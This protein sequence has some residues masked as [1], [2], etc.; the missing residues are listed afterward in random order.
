MSNLSIA[1][2]LFGKDFIGAQELSGISSRLFGEWIQ[3]F[4][5]PEVPEVFLERA[6]RSAGAY[7]LILGP[8]PRVGGLCLLDLRTR[9]GLDPAVSAPCFYNQDWYLHESFAR[10][11]TLKYEWN[12]IAKAI[13]LDSRGEDPIAWVAQKSEGLALPSALLCAYAFFANFLHSGGG[14]LWK[15]E[16]VWCSDVDH[17]GDQIYVG[18]YTDPAGVNKD[19]FSIH[20]HLRIRDYYGVAGIARP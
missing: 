13:A 8:P 10:V 11:T 3:P 1:R 19:G 2:S 12:M 17:Q 9:F 7:L 4:P 16:Y 5:E 15:S 6:R 18:R 20:R 14:G